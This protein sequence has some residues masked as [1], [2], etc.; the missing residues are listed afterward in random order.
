ME[1]IHLAFL[2]KFQPWILLLL[3]CQGKSLSHTLPWPEGLEQHGSREGW[4]QAVQ[5][6]T[7]QEVGKVKL[8]KRLRHVA[9]MR[10]ILLK[11]LRI[12]DF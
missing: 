2:F 11:L 7:L 1:Y 6:T 8:E 4:L 10:W 3:L 9:E 12:A 5:N